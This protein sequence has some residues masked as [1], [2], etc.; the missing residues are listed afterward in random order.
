MQTFVDAGEYTAD[1]LI[2]LDLC[3]KYIQALTLSNICTPEGNYFD[4]AKINGYPTSTSCFTTMHCF[5]QSRPPKQDWKLWKRAIATHFWKNQKTRQLRQPLGE[6]LQPI[7]R[8]HSVWPCYYDDT[9]K[10]CYYSKETPIP[11][12]E[13]HP[14]ECYPFEHPEDIPHTAHPAS[15]PNKHVN[16]LPNPQNP[17]PTSKWTSFCHS[18][19]APVQEDIHEFIPQTD[20]EIK[21]LWEKLTNAKLQIASDGSV[22]KNFGKYG[23]IISDSKGNRIIHSSGN[24]YGWHPSSFRA[25]LAGL[26]SLLH[27]IYCLTQYH[28]HP[29]IPSKQQDI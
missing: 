25:E 10:I 11:L 14:Y 12:P 3:H 19:P 8:R 6:W 26:Q 13:E 27:F 29:Y 22:S 20:H 9:Q 15:G 21:K 2:R 4:E 16:P 18:L 24:V 5:H 17:L 23:W 1:K 28:A 7:A